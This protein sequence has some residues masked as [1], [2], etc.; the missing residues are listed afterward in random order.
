[1]ATTLPTNE[2]NVNYPWQ[3]QGEFCALSGRI[4][5]G[6]EKILQ[7]LHDVSNHLGGEH[8]VLGNRISDGT[9]AILQS[10][11]STNSHLSDTVQ[12]S[13]NTLGLGQGRLSDTIHAGNN[14]LLSG[15]ARISDS[16]HAGTNTL[17]SGQGRLSSEISNAN[18][19]LANLLGVT[20]NRLSDSSEKG[21][22]ATL[23]TGKEILKDNADSSR[24]LGTLVDGVN[25]D[26][27]KTGCDVAADL[28]G[29]ISRSSNSLSKDINDGRVAL[30][31]ASA[32]EL[33]A[34][35][36][37]TAQLTR[38]IND[39]RVA[40]ERTSAA[41]LLAGCR[42]TCEIKDNLGRDIND[43]RVA[44][45][46]TSAAE[47]LAGCRNTN[48][49]R[50]AIG[51][52][53]SA[54][55]L[56]QKDTDLRVAT[57]RADILAGLCA[58]SHH[59]KE[60][61]HHGEDTT[62]ESRAILERQAADYQ[63]RTERQ[64]YESRASIERQAAEYRNVLERQAADYKASSERQMADTRYS[65]ERQASEYKC[66]IELDAHKN[67]EALAKQM[68]EGLCDLREKIDERYNQT[69]Q[70]VRELD[71]GRIRD[72]LAAVEQENLF[73]RLKAAGCCRPNGV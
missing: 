56:G 59:I 41:E 1:M 4:G 15:Q 27:I 13:T 14:V 25:R 36:R 26:V 44:I 34:G 49:L 22:S 45:E 69:A 30:E 57:T 68:A 19:H 10:I 51:S 46:R 29:A 67:R 62:R 20:N 32:E 23:Q 66:F 70:L 18:L 6:T 43:A 9:E 53:N 21:I 47:L 35:C 8:N 5:D 16:I 37:N 38:D 60:R 63:T 52:V 42:N 17:T 31:N 71:T 72:K 50:G 11:C 58:E 73:Y 33:L 48:E 61:I 2:I 55:L 12:G 64:L 39:G 65:I 3:N 54:V 24:F 28:N 7:S 40:V